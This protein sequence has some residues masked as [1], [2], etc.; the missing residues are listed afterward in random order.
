MAGCALQ[1]GSCILVTSANPQ[2]LAAFEEK[3]PPEIRKFCI[4]MAGVERPDG[5]MSKLCRECECMQHDFSELA[6]N[7]EMYEREV[8]VSAGSVAA[9][10]GE[11]A[12]S[13][14]HSQLDIVE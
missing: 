8:E 12:I 4:D 10:R 13:Q 9:V 1:N 2:S 3:L 14:Y 7:P 5:G 6:K 11:Y